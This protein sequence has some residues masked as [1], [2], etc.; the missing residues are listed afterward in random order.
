MK[1]EVETFFH[2]HFC[3]RLLLRFLLLF[4][5]SIYAAVFVAAFV[6][7]PFVAPVSVAA[8]PAFLVAAIST[9]D[10]S[11]PSLSAPA[12]VDAVFLA[13]AVLVTSSPPSRHRWG[14]FQFQ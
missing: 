14:P 5:N 7:F 9:A 13:L 6:V 2:L 10:D 1:R 3:V 11:L 4:L 8:L 12:V